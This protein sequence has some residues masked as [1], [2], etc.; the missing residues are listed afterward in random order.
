M[1]RQPAEQ[2][3]SCRRHA[4]AVAADTAVLTRAAAAPGV[5]QFGEARTGGEVRGFSNALNMRGARSTAIVRCA[6]CRGWAGR[7]A[8]QRAAC[9]HLGS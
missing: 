9:L 1:P 3:A 8:Q 5:D 4:H 6:T 2:R 7:V